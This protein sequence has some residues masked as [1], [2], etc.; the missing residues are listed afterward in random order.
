MII[1]GATRF[2]GVIGNPIKH[3]LSPVIHNYWLSQSSV[4]AVY[5]PFRSEPE[6]ITSTLLSLY[7]LDCL[8]LN[9]TLP[10][11]A[12]AYVIS[13]DA[14]A[15][16]QRLKAANVLI[17]TPQGWLADNT[18]GEGFLYGLDRAGWSPPKRGRVLVLG[19]GGAANAI[20]AALETLSMEIILT[21][22]TETTARELKTAF[23]NIN[24]APWATRQDYAE[25]VDIVVNTTSLG[26]DGVGSPLSSK[27]RFKPDSLVYD[28]IYAPAC[29][30]LL[31]QARSQGVKTLNG[32]SMLVG[33]AIPSFT[34]IF[35]VQP[36]SEP[37]IFKVLESY[38]S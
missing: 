10:F 20:I 9:V 5:L 4:D 12:A 38:G 3:S 23:P 30:P 7:N 1:S 8:G 31:G 36:P 6:H 33:Q 13:F 32:L 16:A 14:T 18:D 2:A 25:A 11:K 26:M 15:R 27:V 24:I 35:G 29:T 22:R 21:N 37:D 19:A 34:K 17:R 28:L